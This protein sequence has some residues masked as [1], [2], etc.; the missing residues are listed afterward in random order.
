MSDEPEVKD[1]VRVENKKWVPLTRGWV[2]QIYFPKMPS[3]CASDAIKKKA[4][5]DD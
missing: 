5:R 1:A 4:E 2:L 3:W